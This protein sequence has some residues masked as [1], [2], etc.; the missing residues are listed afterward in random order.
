[1]GS[2]FYKKAVKILLFL[3][4]FLTSKNYAYFSSQKRGE[5]FK[6]LQHTS[7]IIR[8]KRVPVMCLTKITEDIRVVNHV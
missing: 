8:Y 6:H 4:R 1:M 5:V 2:N 3:N 7:A